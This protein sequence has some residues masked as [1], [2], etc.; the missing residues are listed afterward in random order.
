MKQI[1]LSNTWCKATEENFNALIKLGLKEYNEALT[2]G[3][4]L[5]EGRFAITS[6]YI[7][8]ASKEGL[9]FTSSR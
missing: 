6:P 8:S 9:D 7:V 4:A 3:L 2:F 1:D 5:E